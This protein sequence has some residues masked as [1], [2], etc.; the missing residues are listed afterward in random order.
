[1][2]I[3]QVDLEDLGSVMQKG[4]AADKEKPVVVCSHSFALMDVLMLCFVG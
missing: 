3:L 2:Y 4:A 1:M